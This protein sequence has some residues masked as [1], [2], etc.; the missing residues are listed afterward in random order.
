MDGAEG[1][2]LL[3]RIA[4][5]YNL[6]YFDVGVRLDADGVG[7]IERIAGAIHYLQPGL[8]SLLSRGLYTLE[9]VE[10]ESLK[11]VNP[12]DYRQRLDEGYV[13]GVDEDR[14]AVVSVNAL[15]ASLLINEFLSRIHPHRNLPN[16]SYAQVG[17]NLSEMQFFPERES[18]P[19]EVLRKHVGRGDT[20]PLL[21]RPALS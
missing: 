19:C 20:D 12:E 6:P 5:F 16:D 1:R 10:S 8:S 13:R 2:H 3:N 15:M 18:S 21:E 7:G 9:Q 14:P 4:T 17:V 11:R